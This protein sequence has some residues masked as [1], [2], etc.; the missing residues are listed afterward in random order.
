MPLKTFIFVIN[1]LLLMAP[2]HSQTLEETFDLA[3]RKKDAGN[4]E[5]AIS[6]YRRVLFFDSTEQY[7]QETVFHL[8]QCYEKKKDIKKAHHYYDLSYNALPDDSLRTHIVLKKA[9]LFILKGQTRLAYMELSS[10]PRALPL[11]FCLQRSFYLGVIHYQEEDYDPAFHHFEQ[12]LRSRPLLLDS[13]SHYY[14]ALQKA[15]RLNPS[16]AG[17]LSLAIPGLGQL[18]AGYPGEALNS[19]VL[20]A[21]FL[22]VYIYTMQTYAIL[23]AI[24]SVYPWF[25]RYYMGG[26]FRAEQ[27]AREKKEQRKEEILF[28]ILELHRT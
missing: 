13:L 19:F 12:S 24:L 25:H 14:L 3:Q 22:G 9:F 7:Y 6:A 15:D 16:L 27:L 8:A 28:H 26:F 18:Y 5:E 11:H 10:L 21:A 4:M 1:A 20:N 2:A 23:D 17:Y